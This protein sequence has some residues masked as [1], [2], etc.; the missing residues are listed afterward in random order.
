[1]TVSGR[2]SFRLHSIDI[3]D[4]QRHPNARAV[5][6]SSFYAA[7]ILL[8]NCGTPILLKTKEH[9]NDHRLTGEM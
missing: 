7:R 2:L 6:I 3:P 8:G 1:M 9:R 5:F 4:Q